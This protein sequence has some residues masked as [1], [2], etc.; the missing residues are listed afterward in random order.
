MQDSVLE[1]YF[2]AIQ[3]KFNQVDERFDRQD[4]WLQEIARNMALLLEMH[5]IHESTINYHGTMLGNHERR[6]GKLEKQTV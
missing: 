6:I 3:E 4:N 1:Q 2:T 5:G